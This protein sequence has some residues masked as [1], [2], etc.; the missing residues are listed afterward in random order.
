MQGNPGTNTSVTSRGI[1][2]VRKQHR[3]RSRA[4]FSHGRTRPQPI[5][6]QPLHPDLNPLKTTLLIAALILVC[7]I[8]SLV[9]LMR[10]QSPA[11]ADTIQMPDVTCDDFETWEAANA[12]FAE[13]QDDSEVSHMLDSNA[14]GI[15]CEGLNPHE[16]PIHEIYEVSC[17]EFQHREDAE[18]FFEL[19]DQPDQNLY[20]LDA[21][22]DNRPCESLPPL[23]NT[24]GVLRR[25]N[26]IWDRE[27]G[28]FVELNCSDF[29]TWEEANQI[30][31][32]YG[33]PSFDA[34]NLDGDHDGVPCESL[35]GA[36]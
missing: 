20:G 32:E 21:D 25:L 2:K 34:H 27:A 26:R 36:P 29:E 23:D 14:N 7:A 28:R 6:H 11:G 33:G 12:Y 3:P 35:P 8:A 19:Y 24:L 13:I 17:D 4:Y 5:S 15:P 10:T 18:Y 31:I 30:F 9:I 1:I 22:Y 16:T